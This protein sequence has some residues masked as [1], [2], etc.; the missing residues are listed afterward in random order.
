MHSLEAGW[1]GK[2][3]I[4]GGVVLKRK[5]CWIGGGGGWANP[6]YRRSWG[7]IKFEMERM[8]SSLGYLFNRF[9]YTDR[10]RA[11]GRVIWTC[12]EFPSASAAI[13]PLTLSAAGTS[14]S[15]NTKKNTIYPQETEGGVKL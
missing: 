11:M 12:P 5:G 3:Q 4:R 8:L 13:T 10:I 6:M 7:C 2:K 9:L 1:G 15:L 14:L